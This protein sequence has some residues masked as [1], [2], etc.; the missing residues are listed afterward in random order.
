MD[1]FGQKPV[2]RLPLAKDLNSNN[3][4][5]ASFK[6]YPGIPLEATRDMREDEIKFFDSIV[7]K[8]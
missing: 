2:D 3:G 4:L 5:Q 6:T 1:T 8:E 7:T